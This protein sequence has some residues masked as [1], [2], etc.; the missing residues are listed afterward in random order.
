[1]LGEVL[2]ELKEDCLKGVISYN[3]Y[4]LFHAIDHIMFKMSAGSSNM[5]VILGVIIILT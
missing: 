4:T 3:I 1:M 2:G 5:I